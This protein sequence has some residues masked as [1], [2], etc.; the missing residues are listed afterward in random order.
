MRSGGKADDN[1][2]RFRIAERRHGP[3]PI[4]PIAIGPPLDAR[5]FLKVVN[6]TRAL[7]AIRN[8]ALQNREI[9][10]R[11]TTHQYPA[12][13][14]IRGFEIIRCVPDSS[15]FLDMLRKN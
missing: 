1:Q 8:F 9:V 5:D 14:S 6:Q 7:A 12:V 3:A 10:F 2:T 13:P 15:P 4:S 11:H